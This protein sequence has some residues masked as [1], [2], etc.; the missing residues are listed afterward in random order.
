MSK[1]RRLTLVNW[2]VIAFLF[3][4]YQA[5][6]G[7]F[8]GP[9]RE[10]EIKEFFTPVVATISNETVDVNEMTLDELEAYIQDASN[11]LA[12]QNIDIE[13]VTHLFRFMRED[14]GGPIVMVNLIHRREEPIEVNGQSSDDALEEYSRAVFSFLLQRGSYPIFS[15]EAA[16]NVMETWGLE[17]AEEWSSAAIVRYRSRRTMLQLGASEG[18]TEKHDGKEAGLIKTIA[19]PTTVSLYTSE[20]TI[21]VVFMLLSLGLAGQIAI[22]N[23]GRKAMAID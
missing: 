18:F 22:M 6:H 1:S 10:D 12:E 19:L 5:W 8:D 7:A 11:E 20:L 23:R 15:G 2:G 16:T 13:R 9:L 17:G 14:D 4:L 3:L 21:I